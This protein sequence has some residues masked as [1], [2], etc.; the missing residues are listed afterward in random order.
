MDSQTTLLFGALCA[1]GIISP[2]CGFLGFFVYLLSF[3]LLTGQI[4][5]HGVNM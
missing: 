2:R 3:A 5:I 1:L 4:V